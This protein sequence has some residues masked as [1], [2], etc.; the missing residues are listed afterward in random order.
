[1]TPRTRPRIAEPATADLPA[2]VEELVRAGIEAS[3]RADA[4]ELT[5]EEAEH[6]FD[7]GELPERVERW[8]GS[9]E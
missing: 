5:A 1:M 4:M 7:T 3:L 9:L 8:A 2:D 6:Y